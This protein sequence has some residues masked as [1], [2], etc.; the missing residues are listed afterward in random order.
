MKS[1]TEYDGKS[2]VSKALEAK[3]CVVCYLCFFRGRKLVKANREVRGAAASSH[4][5][6]QEVRQPEPNLAGQ[7]SIFYEVNESITIE[8]RA[9]RV[10][11]MGRP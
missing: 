6:R 4:F 10:T 11:K 1:H 8:E 3:V 7:P 2:P 9:I 5:G